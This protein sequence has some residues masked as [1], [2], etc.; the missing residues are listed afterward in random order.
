MGKWRECPTGVTVISRE[1]AIQWN[2]KFSDIPDVTYYLMGSLF[3]G[4][5]HMVCTGVT[6]L[7]LPS[8]R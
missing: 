6:A 3:P 8:F 2:V 4:P 7:D 5:W 1:L